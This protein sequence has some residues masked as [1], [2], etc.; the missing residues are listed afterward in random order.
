MR[1]NVSK[2]SCPNLAPPGGYTI[3]K[4]G[5]SHELREFSRIFNDAAQELK[6][7]NFAIS[8]WKFLDRLLPPSFE[9]ARIMS[10]PSAGFCMF[11]IRVIGA[12]R[13]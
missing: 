10:L 7:Q 11:L 1:I 2:D 6:I 12:V 4:I 5:R 8:Q 9:L 3:Y 13:G